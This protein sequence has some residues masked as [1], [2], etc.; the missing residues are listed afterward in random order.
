MDLY[1]VKDQSVPI[2]IY[3]NA[4]AFELNDSPE[5]RGP[6]HGKILGVIRPKLDWHTDLLEDTS[7]SLSEVSL[8]ARR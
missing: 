6:V 1:V 8:L 2:F 5:T 7:S 4:L 3:N